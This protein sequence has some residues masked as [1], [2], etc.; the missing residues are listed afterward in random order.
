[1]ETV[2]LGA[3][4]TGLVLAL[5][6]SLRG[7]HVTLIE[8]E[9]LPGGLAAGF[10]VEGTWLEKFYH[11]IFTSDKA[12]I[13]LISDLGLGDKLEWFSPVTASMV[14]DSIYRLDSALS[15]LQFPPISIINRLR[16]GAAIAALKL[17]ANNAYY[18]KTTA[19]AW[20]NRWMGRAAA[21]SVW[22]PLLRGKF[23]DY[24][25]EVSLAWFWARV[26]DR[27][28][29]L[30]YVRGGFQL[31]YNR[32]E[33][34][35]QAMGTKIEY[36]TT[37]QKI[38]EGKNKKLIIETSKG[39]ITADKV[40]STLSTAITLQLLPTLPAF[41]RKYAAVNALGA[42]CLILALQQ[43][44]LPNSIYWLNITDTSMPFLAA[45]EHT[46]MVPANDYK[47][48]VLLYLGNYLP[49]EHPIMHMDKE[50]IL[51]LYLPAL[52]RINPAIDSSWIRQSWS[53]AAPFAQPVVTCSF[54]NQIP[55]H[56]T[57]IKNVFLANMFQ[58]YP[59]DRGQNYAIA[60]ADTVANMLD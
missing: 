57:P 38:R 1:M 49:M 55:P 48:S 27:S 15:V 54:K 21:D 36:Q 22:N 24:A 50:E 23:G 43:K 46:N 12:I 52:Q 44:V 41:H 35:I 25:P 10:E 33:Q 6:R 56:K 34:V 39:T 42:H 11:H 2:I 26:H 58:V 40:I 19:E 51:K 16:M 47:G 8:K 59:H 32:L 5:R 13:Q 14:K 60:M 17:T 29:K 53:F 28:A 18:E 45:V 20:L 30:G 37:A 7:D 9:T 31:V 3:G 4:A